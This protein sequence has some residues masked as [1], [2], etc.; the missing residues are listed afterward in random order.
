MSAAG[1]SWATR[2]AL[3]RALREHG[4]LEEAIRCLRR[5]LELN[6]SSNEVLLF[7]ATT[8]AWL[9]HGEEALALLETAQR[10]DPTTREVFYHAYA[11]AF[12][13]FA[14]GRYAD[15]AR[16]AEEAHRA[17]PGHVG[18]PRLLAAG[19]A[20]SGSG[21]AARAIIERLSRERPD[22][23]LSELTEIS[24]GAAPAFTARYLA[25]LRKAGVGE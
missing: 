13:C 16:W 20:E 15:A 3:G 25:A 4:E 11:M 19:L 5:A 23:R 21:E 10:L 9:D 17:A 24:P 6:P 14:A 2:L 7:L 8:L 22:L 18:A 12:A 1:E